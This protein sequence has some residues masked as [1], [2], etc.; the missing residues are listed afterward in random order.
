MSI[1]GKLK[2]RLLEIPINHK[3]FREKCR[4][5]SDLNVEVKYIEFYLHELCEKNILLKKIEYICPNCGETTVMDDNLLNEI[6]EEEHF[7]CD[8]CFDFVNPKKNTTG[9]VYYDI[10][11]KEKLINW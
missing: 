11:D 5:A 2:E 10:K 6:L 8:N 9:Y 1:K 7:E 3:A 4:L